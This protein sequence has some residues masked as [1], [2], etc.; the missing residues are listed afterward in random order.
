MRLV[1]AVLLLVALTACSSAEPAVSEPAAPPTT[2]ATTPESTPEPE[3]GELRF[4]EI[5][6]LEQPVAFAVRKDDDRLYVA[7]QTGRLRT[8]DGKTVIDLSD[9]VS[10]G[11][12]QGLLGVAF[13][14]T[15]RW[16]YLDWTDVQGHT[17]ITEWAYD[18]TRATGRRDVLKQ[19]QPFPNHNGGQLAFGPDGFLYIA[20]GDGGSG[21]DPQGNGQ[22]LGTLLG[23]I[24]RIDPR[25]EPYKI[26]DDNPFVGK[27]GA[28]GEI[29][30]Y[31]L[32]NPWRFSFDR[33]TGDLWI[34][35]V[36]QNAWEE[37]DYQRADSKG[38]ENYGWNLREGD[39]PFDG[40]RGDD[41][42][43]PVIVYP[44][45]E[46]GNCSVIAGYVYR[47]T[48]IP[49]LRGR[50]LYGDFCAGWIKAAPVGEL[51]GAAEVGKVERLSSFG[52]GP[53]GELYA[54]SLSGRLYRIDPA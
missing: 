19:D 47:G 22:D 16:V 54:L 2:E 42:V 50:F 17:H 9:E 35:D 5:A 31:G 48:K 6:R 32:R 41:L 43:D 49:W 15:G 20:L 30:A 10:G 44:L 33:E 38:G 53:D 46:G 39:Q 26:P 40:G 25:G 1:V 8:S 37:V 21:G 11:N 12:E 7:E 27:K 34:G 23:K 3:R 36:G 52:E 4:E 18:G 51:D 14:P 29:W 28:R 45:N 13:H 24:L